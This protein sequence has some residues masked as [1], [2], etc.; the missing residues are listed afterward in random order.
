M[1]PE[2]TDPLTSG[3]LATALFARLQTLLVAVAT[4]VV[5]GL[6]GAQELLEMTFSSMASWGLRAAGVRAPPLM[7]VLLRA[8]TFATHVGL[9]LIATFTAALPALDGLSS[10]EAFGAGLG[11]ATAVFITMSACLSGRAMSL[12]SLISTCARS[13]RRPT[14]PTSTDRPA[15]SSAGLSNRFS[16]L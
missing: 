14:K 6:V 4:L 5:G 9:C 11:A 8:S 1:E 16:E 3:A 15:S 13:L 12:Q 10:P 2:Q 7:P